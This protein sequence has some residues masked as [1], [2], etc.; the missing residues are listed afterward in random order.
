MP[1]YRDI[2]GDTP[3]GQR[4]AQRL[5]TLRAQLDTLPAKRVSG[6]LLLA[7]W[8]IREFG[9][10]KFGGRLPE[11]YAYIAEILSRFDLIAIQEVREDLAALDKV[12]S[13]LGPWWD[14]VFTDVT[15][16]R[17]GNGE[18]MAFLYDG[19]KVRFGGLAG[20]CVLP[21]IALK[22]DGKTI[23]QPA[24]QLYR[25]PFLVGFKTGWVKFQI[26][27]VH[28]VWGESVAESPARIEEIRQIAQFL[29]DRTKAKGDFS[30]NMILLGDFN[31]FSRSD[32]TMQVITNAGFIVPDALQ[33]VPASNVGKEKRFYDQ[34]AFKLDHHTR[35]DCLDAGVLDFYQSVFTDADEAE[36]APLMGDQYLMTEGGKER[37]PPQRSS[38]YRSMWR[39]FQMSDHLPMWV[40]LDTDF[41]EEYLR[42][43]A[44]QS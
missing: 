14:V 15:E 24:Q 6:N 43:K 13:L 40:E 7:S 34:I 17:P 5:L 28:I 26:C 16:G 9:Q 22:Q 20:E 37:T 25:T 8:N 2:R 21:P 44:G 41:S 42:A 11:S 35:L 3:E 33:S 4:T 19:R 36:Y 23:Y 31:I 1:F 39:T 10:T 38:F 32:K 30:T 27:T 18:R 29:S 12:R